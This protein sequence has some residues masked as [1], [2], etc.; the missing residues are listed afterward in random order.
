MKVY[1]KQSPVKSQ[2]FQRLWFYKW[3]KSTDKI[4]MPV[5]K[6]K[7]DLE[8]PSDS[9]QCLQQTGTCSQA[10]DQTFF[11]LVVFSNKAF[12]IMIIKSQL[13]RHQQFYTLI[14]SVCTALPG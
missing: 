2:L 6:H 10:Q 5:P 14:S 3:Q 11:I 1:T 9:G 8:S 12:G 7:C 4:H 13:C